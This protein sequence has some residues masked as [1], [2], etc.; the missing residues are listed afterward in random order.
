KESLLRL[1]FSIENL[2]SS[3]TYIGDSAGAMV[4]GSHYYRYDKNNSKVE[5]HEGILPDLKRI[6]IVH[7][8]NPSYTDDY[9][10]EKVQVFAEKHSLEIITLDENQEL[11][12]E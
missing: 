5:F 4:L 9:L 8:D 11:I 3:V 2:K 1:G 10:R 12:I 7:N 6:F